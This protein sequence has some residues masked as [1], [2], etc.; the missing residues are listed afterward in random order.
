MRMTR[1]TSIALLCS[2]LLLTPLAQAAAPGNGQDQDEDSV[3]TWG[4]W[5]VLAPAAGGTPPVS[6]PQFEAPV[7]LRAGDSAAL[8]GEFENVEPAEAPVVVPNPPSAPP[9][10]GDPRTSLPVVEE[11]VVVPNSP[12][13]PP[14]SGDPR[15]SQPVVEEPVVVP[16]SPSAPPPSGGPRG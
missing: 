2:G 15:M 14:P 10:S 6:V 13:A 11:P 8:T 12:S 1:Y 9:P 7:Q 3:Y 5:E 16:N 4:R